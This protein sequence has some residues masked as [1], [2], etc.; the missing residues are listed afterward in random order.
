MTIIN[1]PEQLSELVGAELG[2]SDWLKISQEMVD[3]FAEATE[4][5][6][7]IHVDEQKAAKTAFGGTI[8]HGFLLLSLLPRLKKDIARFD[9]AEM[10]INYGSDKVR[11]LMPV[12]TGS[13]VR[14]AVKLERMEDSPSGI[15]LFTSNVLE[16][17]GESR[18]CMV[19]DCITLLRLRKN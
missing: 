14:L 11:Y 2:K 5:K 10:A 13:E 19:A 9:C 6:Q 7:W 17:K 15:K 4:D 12:R 18:P 1:S 8:A 16:I 3:L